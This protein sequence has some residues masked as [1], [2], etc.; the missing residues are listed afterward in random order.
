M[1]SMAS[2]GLRCGEESQLDEP[3]AGHLMHDMSFSPTFV[4]IGKL[5][6]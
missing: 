1:I 3:K 6:S 2:V 4:L 5:F